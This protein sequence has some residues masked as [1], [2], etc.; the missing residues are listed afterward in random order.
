LETVKEGSFLKGLFSGQPSFIEVGFNENHF[1]LNLGFQ[2][3][4]QLKAP[5]NWQ[6]IKKGLLSV[7][8][9]D[10]DALR[11]WIDDFLN[12]TCST[13]SGKNVSGWIDGL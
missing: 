3:A 13:S 1:E 2:K 8:R 10:S 11:D 5:S 7:P 4:E 6:E 12:K 9:S